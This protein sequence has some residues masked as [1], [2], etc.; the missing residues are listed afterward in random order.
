MYI[1]WCSN[2]YLL[3][4]FVSTILSGNHFDPFPFCCLFKAPLD[5]R[6]EDKVRTSGSSNFTSCRHKRTLSH[7]KKS[8][9]PLLSMKYLLFNGNPYNGF[10]NPNITSYNWVVLF[11]HCSLV[12]SCW[13]LTMDLSVSLQYGSTFGKTIS[14]VTMDL[15]DHVK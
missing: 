7:A 13:K 15:R 12:E 5:P 11:I 10:D 2:E 14:L 6:T 9:G 3:I 8:W 1:I 4:F